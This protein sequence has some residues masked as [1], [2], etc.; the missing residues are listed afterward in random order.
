VVPR[1]AAIVVLAAA[2]VTHAQT[3]GRGAAAALTNETEY[4]GWL[5]DVTPVEIRILEKG[6]ACGT[7][8]D[9][10]SR[11]SRRLTCD[12]AQPSRYRLDETG[13]VMSLETPPG[14][15]IVGRL[16]PAKGG[17]CSSLVGQRARPMAAGEAEALARLVP[18]LYPRGVPSV[19]PVTHAGNERERSRQFAPAEIRIY[20]SLVDSEG[21]EIVL[22]GAE[23]PC[24]VAVKAPDRIVELA[25]LSRPT[26]EK[27]ARVEARV[28]VASVPG[29]A[30]GDFAG[31]LGAFRTDAA[32]K[33]V[34]VKL[35]HLGHRLFTRMARGDGVEFVETGTG[36]DASDLRR[37][38]SDATTLHYRFQ[39][40]RLDAARKALQVITWVHFDGR[41]GRTLAREER[42]TFAFDPV[43]RSWI[44]AD[45]RDV[46]AAA[47][48]APEIE[49]H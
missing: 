24:L 43:N 9:L 46:T 45:V 10:T 8:T 49:I 21:E 38:F 14:E 13:E 47:K 32:S 1:G 7:I 12:T 44:E 6:A 25:L 27:P 18:L 33:H 42:S 11:K 15:T 37:I 3:Q 35:G 41:H 2:A 20:S 22:L 4:R 34:I 19:A 39:L 36:P 29:G 23:V 28:A 48:D 40:R 17:T 16:C 26:R 5:G 31:G 30:G